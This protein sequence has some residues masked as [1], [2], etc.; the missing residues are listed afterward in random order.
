MNIISE[1]LKDLSYNVSIEL[2]L[3][4]FVIEMRG[5]HG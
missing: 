2:T 1:I 3:D 5:C 4:K